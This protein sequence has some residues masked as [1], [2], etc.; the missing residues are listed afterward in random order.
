MTKLGFFSKL[1]AIIKKD[2]QPSY[3]ES[4][5][6]S[7]SEKIIGTMLMT[8]QVAMDK[9]DYDKAADVFKDILKLETNSTAAYN[10][11]S[12]YAQGKGVERDFTEGAYY[13]HQAELL[14]DEQAGKLCLKCSMD[15]VH[16]NFNDKTPE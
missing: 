5:E 13:F 12:L 4:Q 16:Q 14:G 10:L 2:K 11:G 7:T 6:N 15:F 3:T 8:A 9:E 1:F